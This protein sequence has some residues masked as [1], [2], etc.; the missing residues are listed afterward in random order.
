MN[1]NS[2]ANSTPAI[3]PA[4]SGPSLPNKGMLRI[5]DQIISSTAASM[6]R[7]PPCITGETS[8]AAS[9]VATLVKPQMK[10]HNTMVAR[11]TES[12]GFRFT[13]KRGRVEDERG[14]CRGALDLSSCVLSVVSQSKQRSLADCGSHRFAMATV[15]PRAAGRRHG[16]DEGRA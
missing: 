13:K 1:R 15:A 3:N 9:L 8:G 16:R 2:P 11:A 12:R 5:R 7:S 6:E 4:L 10:Q 14:K